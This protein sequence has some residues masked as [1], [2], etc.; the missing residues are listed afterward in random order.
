MTRDAI[1]AL[2]TD[3]LIE[4]VRNPSNLFSVEHRVAFNELVRRR[5][6][7]IA[8]GAER[9]RDHACAGCRDGQRPCR[10]GAPNLCGWPRA[11]ND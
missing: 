10:E 2:P 6:P 9:F 5:P 1:H 7:A 4:L 11:R 8:F 3:Q